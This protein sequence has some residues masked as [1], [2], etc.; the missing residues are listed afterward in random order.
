MRTG[1]EVV[2]NGVSYSLQLRSHQQNMGRPGEDILEGLKGFFDIDTWD[3][4]N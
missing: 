4:H 3:I 2:T 1:R